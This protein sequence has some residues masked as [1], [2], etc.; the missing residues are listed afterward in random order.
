MP[1]AVRF[2]G[3]VVCLGIPAILDII[4]RSSRSLP[5]ILNITGTGGLLLRSRSLSLGLLFSCL[6][7][8]LLQLLL[9]LFPCPLSSFSKSLLLI[10]L[11]KLVP[12]AWFV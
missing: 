8:G 3:F 1:L 6:L 7:L 12:E 10:N 2:V 11:L 5:V 4:L 9:G